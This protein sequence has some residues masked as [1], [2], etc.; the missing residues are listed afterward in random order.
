MLADKGIDVIIAGSFGPNMKE[1]L[2]DRNLKFEEKKGNAKEI[3]E[4][5]V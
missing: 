4:E 2:K 5:M 1:A 3:V